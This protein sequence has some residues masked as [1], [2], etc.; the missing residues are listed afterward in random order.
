MKEKLTKNLGLKLL[1]LFMAI[2]IWLII[3]N[4][5]DPVGKKPF[6]N[7]MVTKINE[8]VLA[9]KDKVYEVVSGDT[10]DVVVKAKRSVLQTLRYSDIK[11]VADLSELSLVNAVEIKVTVPG[12]DK[13]IVEITKDISTMKVSLENLKTEQFRINVVTQGEVASGFYIKDKIASPNIIEVSGAETVISRI[14]EVV[15][16]VNVT[17]QRG[18][19]V[20]T[21]VPKVYD[22]NGTLMDSDTLNLNY[23]EVD[24]TVNLLQTKTVS[25]FIEVTGTPYPGYKYIDLNYEPKQVVIAGEKDELDKVRYIMGE[26]NIDNQ[27]EDIEDEVNIADFIKNDVILIDDNQT[28]VINVK[29]ERLNSKDISFDTSDIELKNLPEGLTAITKESLLHVVLYGDNDILNPI[30]KYNLR[31]Y[32]DLKEAKVGNNT[33]SVEFDLPDTAITLETPSVIVDVSKTSG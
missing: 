20:R 28:A 30:N 10:V 33:L 8:N 15:V 19:F 24:V 26:Y 14:K 3:L 11:A 12:H 9:Q 4:M 17:N 21:A 18:S 32:I 16:E 23:D 29:I 6:Y 5:A 7:V 25:L 2:F 13:D 1:S 27:R 22:K 31:P